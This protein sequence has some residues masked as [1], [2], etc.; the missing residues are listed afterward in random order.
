MQQKVSVFRCPFL[1]AGKS[2]PDTR[3]PTPDTK[4]IDRRHGLRL[5]F[6]KIPLS[7]SYKKLYS[8]DKRHTF[9]NSCRGLKNR[10]YLPFPFLRARKKRICSIF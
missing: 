5:F 3:Y 1:D 10:F 6:I 8:E 9:R 2:D 7:N 4:S